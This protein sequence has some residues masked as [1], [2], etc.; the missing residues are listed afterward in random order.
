MTAPLQ[1]VRIVD[2]S[3]VIMG[4]YA[5]QILADLG[6]DVLKVES[7]KGDSM[8]AV[9]PARSKSM[10]CLFLHSNRNKRSIAID[11]KAAE[12]RAACLDILRDADVMVSNIRPRAMARL[13]LSYGDV[14][15]VNDSIIYV[16]ACGFGSDG[17]YAGKPAY[18]DL[19][20]GLSGL[21]FLMRRTGLPDPVYTP[22]LIADRIVGLHVANSVSAALVHRLQT[23]NGQYIEVPMFESL[24]HMILSDHMGGATFVPQQGDM[25]YARLLSEDRRPY[26]TRDGH[27]CVVVYTDAHWRAFLD[28]I[29]QPERFG[30]DPRFSSLAIRT[31]HIG[32][33]YGMVADHLR[34]ATSKE[35]LEKLSGADI[36]AMPLHTPETLLHDPHLADVGFFYE[37][38]HPSEGRLRQMRMPA[39]WSTARLSDGM[40]APRLGQHTCDV[41]RECGWNTAQIQK[42]INKNIIYQS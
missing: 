24:A 36:P 2:F 23:G 31:Q 5:T 34:R 25:G 38:D 14:R 39:T 10:G 1:G 29:G 30:T 35:W 15:A 19:I 41:L 12:G 16:D 21:P 18:D 26:Q 20:Q 8:R 7:L 6:A 33:L 3:S 11:L 4:P 40:P 13:R 27:I 32:E 28:L 42:L 37:Y 22:A 9:G 17:R